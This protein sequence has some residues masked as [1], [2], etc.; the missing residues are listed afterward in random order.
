MSE[1]GKSCIKA[2][3]SGGFGGALETELLRQAREHGAHAVDGLGMLIY[4]AADAIRIWT[5]QDAPVEVMR[6]AAMQALGFE[7]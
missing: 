5:G 4:Q 3:G 2:C 6:R 1:S 7:E